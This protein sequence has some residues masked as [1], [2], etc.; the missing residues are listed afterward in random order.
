MSADRHA[1]FK[2]HLLLGTISF[3]LCFAAWGLI[4]AFAP[5]FRKLFQ[6][7]ATQTAALVAAPVLLG[8]LARIP[9]GMLTDRLGGRLV[10][11]ALMIV[12]AV[13]AFLV[14]LAQDFLQL[15]LVAFFL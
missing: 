10:F 2:L 7:T 5:E 14:P 3:T 4:S 6:L 13:P 1:H 12:G 15:L 8:S 11:S 9:A